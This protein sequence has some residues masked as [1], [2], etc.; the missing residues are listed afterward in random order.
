M[1]YVYI[2]LLFLRSMGKF[3][4][5]REITDKI[6]KIIRDAEK[7]IILTSPYVQMDKRIIEALLE[8]LKH[9]KNLQIT[10]IYGKRELP[11]R[12]RKKLKDLNSEKESLRDKNIN[13]YYRESLHAKCYMNENVAIVTSMNL[14]EYSQVNNDEFGIMV[15]KGDE[16]ELYSSIEKEVNRII[17]YSEKKD[18]SE[19]SSDKE[20]GYCI[21]CG[22]RI[23]LDPMHP[24]CRECYAKWNKYKNKNY[25][26]KYCHVCGKSHKST[27]NRPACTSCWKK[28][29]KTLKFPS[30]KR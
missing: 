10:L 1:R 2:V 13:V 19:K 20:M 7:K 29:H 26:E 21:R 17:E 11:A 18:L 14:H 25:E 3:L 22:K 28:H 24:Y 8:A 9:N 23:P 12:E 6:D 27:I 4:T 30:Q 5:T 16:K 15:T